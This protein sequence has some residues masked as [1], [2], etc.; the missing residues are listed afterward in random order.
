MQTYS[1][2]AALSR[3]GDEA[4]ALC[5][6]WQQLWGYPKFPG[7][8]FIMDVQT[9]ETKDRNIEG[10][11]SPIFQHNPSLSCSGTKKEKP[12]MMD[13]LQAATVTCKL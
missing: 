1:A 4:R 2:V 11:V 5:M 13:I 10:Y 9:V 6:T 8:L 3:T 12:S 7:I